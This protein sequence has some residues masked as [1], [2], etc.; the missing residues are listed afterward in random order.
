MEIFVA[1][2]V[3]VEV[4]KQGA[5]ILVREDT[6]VAH[7]LE[8]VNV[9]QDVLQ[10]RV[11]VADGRKR[12]VKLARKPCGVQ[13]LGQMIPAG[14]RRDEEVV[15]K[16]R[17]LTIAARGLFFGN[18]LLLQLLR[19][20]LAAFRLETVR[21]AL[22]EQHAQDVV[23]IIRLAAQEIGGGV[24]VSF[25]LRKRQFGHGSVL[26]RH[27]AHQP[28]RCGDIPPPRL[29]LDQ[30]PLLSLNATVLPPARPC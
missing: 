19:E 11:R 10:R 29:T 30:T 13:V 20:E 6:L 8:E 1:Q 21:A 5:A 22:E 28:L 4:A 17:V 7:H 26:L 15:V 9:R 2:S 12:L 16:I 3:A 18:A 24:E 27:W 23:L 14:G 25:K